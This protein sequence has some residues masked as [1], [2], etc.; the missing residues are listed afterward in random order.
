MLQLLAKIVRSLGQQRAHEVLSHRF[1]RKSLEVT[2]FSLANAQSY[3]SPL[4][5]DDEQAALCNLLDY[6]RV[7]PV[8]DDIIF[9]AQRGDTALFYRLLDRMSR[10]ENSALPEKKIVAHTH[11]L[12]NAL[13]DQSAARI[14]V[15]KGY[16]LQVAKEGWY[17]ARVV[18]RDKLWAQAHAEVPSQLMLAVDERSPELVLWLLEAGQEPE[19][20]TV[21]FAYQTR[22]LEIAQL[23]EE[24]RTCFD[25]ALVSRV[26]QHTK[27]IQKLVATHEILDSGMRAFLTKKGIKMSMIESIDFG[28]RYLLNRIFREVILYRAL[29]YKYRYED[30]VAHNERILDLG[31]YVFDLGEFNELRKI[32]ASFDKLEKLYRSLPEE[33]QKAV[34]GHCAFPG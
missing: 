33:I 18:L 34:M 27:D 19:E 13:E 29:M 16:N 31:F 32:Y 28:Q 7:S 5:K 17:N 12:L 22:Q 4:E 21:R 30:T 14:F 10:P 20:E 2:L 25:L 3:S 15:Q 26:E 9:V 24:H 8:E 23:L 6:Y 11:V 1:A